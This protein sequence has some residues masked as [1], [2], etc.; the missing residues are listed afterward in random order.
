MDDILRQFL[1]NNH[2]LKDSQ[3]PLIHLPIDPSIISP[4]ECQLPKPQH[5]YIGLIAMAILSSPHKKM[6]LAEVYEWIMTEYPYFRS[7]G[8]GW[9][10]SIRHNL[11]LNDCFVKAGRAANG[12]GHY[13][14][15][16]PACVRDFERGDFRR[17][18]AQRKVRRHM[19]LQVEDGESSDE[20]ESV[21]SDTSP[22]MFSPAFWNLNCVPRTPIKSFTIEAILQHN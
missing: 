5:S 11:S 18:R 2:S 9:R 12:K 20:E 21:G 1:S 10:N 6:V 15:V 13:W 14:A 16:H 3:F 4:S 7:R 17:R 19:G 22:P 8:A